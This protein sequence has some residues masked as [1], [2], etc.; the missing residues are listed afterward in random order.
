VAEPKTTTWPLD[1][2]TLAKHVLLR[3]YLN[4]WLPKITRYNGRVIFCDGFA[5]PGVYNDG[6]D[7]SPVIALKALLEHSYFPKMKAEVVYLFIEENPDRCSSLEKVIKEQFKNL[8]GNVKYEIENHT[9]E[10]ALTKLLDDL[11]TGAAKLAPTFAFIDPFGVSGVPLSIIKRLMAHR[12]CEVF[13][14]IMFGYMH[15][16][17]SRPEF[18]RHCDE[19]FG[20]K[21]WRQAIELSGQQRETFL[22]ELYQSQL[23]DPN[24]GVGAE[25]TRYF[26]MKD[27]R[28]VTIYD[29]FFATNAWQGIDAMKEA[30]WNVS[31]DY[32]FS[33]A[34]DPAQEVLFT[35]DPD[36]NH[37]FAILADRYRGTEQPW[38]DVEEPIRRSPFRILKRPFQ[39]ESKRDNPRFTIIP[40]TGARQGTLDARSRIR[41]SK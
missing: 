5:G 34:T 23:L 29:L 31:G 14:T 35:K 41:F 28:N 4:A 37:L 33:D 12:R 19:L 36:W 13:I 32:V 22:R 30:M 2:H 17:I 38:P 16:F 20:T 8:P 3:K 39:Q 40:G 9:Y 1:P 21:K 24:E 18:E 7:G 11:D 25:Y 6:E 26:T 15:R 10:E 27:D